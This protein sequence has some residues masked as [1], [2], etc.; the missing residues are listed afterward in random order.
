[1]EDII[2]AVK[3]LGKLKCRARAV[4]IFTNDR[5]LL[6]CPACGL[7]EDVTIEGLLIT[8]PEDSSL[9]E[10]SGLRFKECD[11]MFICPKCGMSIAGDSV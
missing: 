2:A 3:E 10:D 5:E 6:A 7:I 1:M 4:G 11:G 8:Y 9:M